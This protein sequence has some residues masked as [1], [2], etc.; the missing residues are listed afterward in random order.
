VDCA[1]WWIVAD[2]SVQSL[3]RPPALRPVPGA[4]PSYGAAFVGRQPIL[5]RSLETYGYELLYRRAGQQGA[6]FTDRDSASAEV[7]LDAFLEFG[8]D[9]LAGGRRAFIN[10]TR[11]VLLSE[12]CRE[13]PAGQVVLEILEDQPCD[14]D[15][16]H[17]VRALAERGFLIALDD[18]IDD[19]PRQRLLPW[20]SMIKLDVLGVDPSQLRARVSKLASGRAAL[21]AERVESQEDLDRC[22]HL[23]FT[24]FQGYFFARPTTIKGRRI[25]V[26]RLTALKVLAQL[27]DPNSSLDAIADSV[28]ADVKLSYQLLRAANSAATAHLAPVDSLPTAL[29]R[30]GRHQ[31]RAWIT[32]LGLSGATGKPPAVL[33]LA[34]QR[35]RMCEALAL[36]AGQGQPSTWF[37]AGL[38]SSLD[39]VFDAPLDRVI[40]DLNLAG[41]VVSALLSRSGELGQALDAVIAFERGDWAKVRCGGLTPRDFTTAYRSA[42][43]WVGE[44][45]AALAA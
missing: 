33:A 21:L 23:G 27:S 43:Q 31:L 1:D 24:Y 39:L 5:D 4:G 8:L 12:F 25:P 42:L 13:L 45:E 40:G 41:P 35:A 10:V 2:G 44:W 6:T 37:M 7:A 20:T 18:Y 15:V 11:E 3:R 14:D 30:I 26:E 28:A 17:A 16:E 9:A 32:V 36:A 38:F 22:R 29:M 19:D 34:L